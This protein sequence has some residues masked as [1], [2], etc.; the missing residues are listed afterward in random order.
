MRTL[1]TG[2]TGTTQGA[3]LVH[4]AG[5]KLGLKFSPKVCKT[6]AIID[7][8]NVRAVCLFDRFTE[9]DCCMHIASDGSVN[10]ATP[11]FVYECFAYPFITLKQRRLTGLVPSRDTRT[12]KFDLK[13]GF[14]Q[15][16]MLR[17]GAPD[18]DLL[19]LGML[20]QECRYITSDFFKK[21]KA[22]EDG[23]R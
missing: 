5:K 17:M 3:Y 23:Q 12:L 9:G 4:W 15:E 8:G 14:K 18:D 10:W 13:L 7:S 2:R 6:I 22:R 16:G 19:V 11:R 20:A 1:V 21:V